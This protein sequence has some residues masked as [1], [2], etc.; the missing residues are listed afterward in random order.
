MPDLFDAVLP[1]LLAREGGAKFTNRAADRGGPTRWGI[2]AA[3]LGEFR[4]LGRPATAAEVAALERP[5]AER[6]YRADFW[7]KPGYDRVAQVSP[8]V[9]EEMLDTGVNMGTGWPGKWLQQT[10]N[11]CNRRGRDWPD[12]G[13]DGAIGPM[14]LAALRA[15]LAK[16]GA[17]AGEDLV[18]KCL[19]GLQWARYWAILEAGG[20]NGDQEENF[21]G[22]ISQRIGLPT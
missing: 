14:T 22:W 11:A 18:L 21:C 5:E 2:T 12:V 6:I 8:R 9:A 13:V 3:K 7:I 15:L 16:R 10:L 4:R 17:R 1:G 20:P 19:N